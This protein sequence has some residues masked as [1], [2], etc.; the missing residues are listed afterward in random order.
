[1]GQRGVAHVVRVPNR[2]GTRSLVN[3]ITCVL[4]SGLVVGIELFLELFFCF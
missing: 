1:V 3:D 2:T 4:V